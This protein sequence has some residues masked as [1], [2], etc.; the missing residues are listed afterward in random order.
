MFILEN[1]KNIDLN[2]YK[3]RN[4]YTDIIIDPLIFKILLQ[5]YDEIIKIDI[6]TYYYTINIMLY[7]ANSSLAKRIF[8]LNLLLLIN[9]SLYV[10]ETYDEK[11]KYK[12]EIER[13]V[14]IQNIL[15]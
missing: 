14:K 4:Y 1:K 13:K 15:D 3:I 7:C 9:N 10:F 11:N 6:E 5:E 2:S 8:D 12:L